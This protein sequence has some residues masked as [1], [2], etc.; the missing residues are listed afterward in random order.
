MWS[1]ENSSMPTNLSAFVSGPCACKGAY[2][3]IRGGVTSNTPESWMRVD[4]GSLRRLKVSHY[5]LRT[6]P[7]GGGVRGNRDV[8]SWELQG[9]DCDSGP[10]TTLDSH[11]NDATIDRHKQPVAAWPV[12]VTMQLISCRYL[13]IVQCGPNAHGNHELS[14][15]GIEFWGELTDLATL[16]INET[17]TKAAIL[18]L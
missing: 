13:R 4:L 17:E 12:D 5:A 9:A 14:I 1:A 7:W 11:V 8:R 3:P 18:D 6:S 10:W 16:E 15:A 2:G